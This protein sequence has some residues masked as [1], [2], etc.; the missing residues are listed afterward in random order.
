MRPGACRTAASPPDHSRSGGVTAGTGVT[1]ITLCLSD[2]GNPGRAARDSGSSPMPA[3]HHP[4]VWPGRV[5]ARPG[6]SDRSVRPHPALAGV[7]HVRGL[8]D[9]RLCPTSCS[10]SWRRFF[11]SG[12]STSCRAALR[13]ADRPTSGDSLAA[14]W[15]RTY[16]DRATR[17]RQGN[18]KGAIP[19]SDTDSTR[20]EMIAAGQP[21]RGAG[22]GTGRAP[23]D[24]DNRRAVTRLR[25]PRLRGTL[26]G[27]Q[28]QER[29]KGSLE[30][31][32]HPRIYFGFNK[33]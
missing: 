28:A 13:L 16:C 26:R 27:R 2:T 21:G 11:T 7:C 8:V 25:D 9:H 12:H 23:A 33:A 3:D 5:T 1:Q 32:H 29:V 15:R 10:G 17:K 30:F 14:C 18:R 24:L 20:R 22:R 6:R 4:D 19:M 31:Q